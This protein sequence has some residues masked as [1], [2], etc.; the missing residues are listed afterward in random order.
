[1]SF[2][3]RAKTNTRANTETRPKTRKRA[4]TRPKTRK[5]Q[6]RGG[7]PAINIDGISI[8]WFDP[9]PQ[10]CIDDLNAQIKEAFVE[11]EEKDY[12]NK[13]TVGVLAYYNEPNTKQRTIVGFIMIKADESSPECWYINWV[14]VKPQHRK[15][16]IAQN[17]LKIVLNKN[18]PCIKLNVQNGTTTKNMY[19]AVGFIDTNKPKHMPD[20]M[21]STVQ[22][23]EMILY[24][25]P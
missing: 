19:T 9:V 18:H 7:S 6:Q 10:E 17:M 8:E 3:R 23:D 25:R 16:G 21:G 2:S 22:M 20:G 24:R 11:P 1:M 13:D 4:N 12:V 14:F 5:R 15:K